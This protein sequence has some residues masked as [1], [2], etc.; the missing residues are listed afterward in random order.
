MGPGFQLIPLGFVAAGLLL[1]AI[2]VLTLR[3]TRRFERTA[4][5]ATGTVTDVRRQA[6]GPRSHR[7]LVWIPAVRFTTADGRT[8]DGAASGGT[9][10]RTHEPGQPVEV[11]YDPADP[12]RFRVEGTPGGIAFNAVFIVAGAVLAF[13][14]LVAFA[15][16]RAFAE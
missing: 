16:L 13:L 11:R 1:A 5:R 4:Q 12:S 9:N 2:G 15:A 6:V 10:L 14:G 3:A 8:V 7:G